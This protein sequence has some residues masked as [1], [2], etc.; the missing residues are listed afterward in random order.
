MTVSIGFCGLEADDT[1]SS[2]FDR[3]DKALYCAKGKGRNQVCNY[4]DLV[5]SGELKE[6]VAKDSD[7]DY[8]F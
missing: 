8:F 3:A 7:A 1:P 4:T 2:A 6:T 5:L